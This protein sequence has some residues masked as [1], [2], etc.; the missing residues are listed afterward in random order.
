L[1]FQSRGLRSIHRE[2]P[3]LFVERFVL[4]LEPF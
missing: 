2:V 1:E 3:V 4:W